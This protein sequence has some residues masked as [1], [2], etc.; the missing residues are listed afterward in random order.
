M[1]LYFRNM[2]PR[3]LYTAFAVFEPDVCSGFGDFL[4]KQWFWIQP[5]R[6]PYKVYSGVVRGSSFWAYAHDGQGNIWQGSQP[7]CL[8]NEAATFCIGTRTCLNPHFM[9]AF[10]TNNK[11][12][13]ILNFN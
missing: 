5:D 13:Q 10:P 11:P 3:I 9:G 1:S 8:S 12:D 4:V 2:T 7:V 6:Q